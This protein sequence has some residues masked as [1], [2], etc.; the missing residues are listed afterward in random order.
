MA[1][2]DENQPFAL[3]V[4]FG[5]IIV[6]FTI[7]A[8]APSFSMG[9]LWSAVNYGD[10][11]Q[12]AKLTRDGNRSAVCHIMFPGTD[13][14]NTIHCGSEDGQLTCFIRVSDDFETPN[15]AKDLLLDGLH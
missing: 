5:V 6:V 2:K 9:Q 7:F 1:L 14:I 15:S 10:Y 3:G 11:V 13:K 4:L 12:C 8:W